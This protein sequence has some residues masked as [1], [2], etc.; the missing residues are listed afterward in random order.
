MKLAKGD[1]AVV[2]QM[3][4]PTINTESQIVVRLPSAAGVDDRLGKG[5]EIPVTAT[6][7]KRSSSTPSYKLMKWASS[8]RVACLMPSRRIDRRVVTKLSR[9]SG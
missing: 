2:A 8:V 5:G 6:C 4:M 9:I 3:R 1:T 7:S